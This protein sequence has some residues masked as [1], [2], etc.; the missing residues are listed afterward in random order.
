MG[1]AE[2]SPRGSNTASPKRLRTC[3]QEARERPP[4]TVHGTPHKP[5][6]GSRLVLT[7]C[8]QS[9]TVGAQFSRHAS[10]P[11]AWP[12]SRAGTPSQARAL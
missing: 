5:P 7:H 9:P 2:R 4:T 8:V 3:L 12:M 11:A 10:V 1:E 6:E